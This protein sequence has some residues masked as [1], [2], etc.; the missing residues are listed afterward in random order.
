[1]KGCTFLIRVL[2]LALGAPGVSFA[3]DLTDDEA[4]AIL[5][6][7]SIAQEYSNSDRMDRPEFSEW[8]AQSFRKP[9]LAGDTALEK[10]ARTDW[11]A[12]QLPANFPRTGK[13][14]V[15]LLQKCY[16]NVWLADADDQADYERVESLADREWLRVA[17]QKA[18]VE[19]GPLTIVPTTVRRS[20]LEDPSPAPWIRSLNQHLQH[21]ASTTE[22]SLPLAVFEPYCGES[23]RQEPSPPPPPPPPPPRPAQ[24][25]F[26]APPNT[27]LTIISELKSDI[28]EIRTGSRYTASCRGWRTISQNPF[29]VTGT[30]Y[31]Y[32]AIRPGTSETH[33][34]FT[35]VWEN[36]DPN[37]PI[38]FLQ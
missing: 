18:G 10:K 17:F 20:S 2:A 9:F 7:K 37:N 5:I 12:A 31:R 27:T 22:K 14:R 35:V 29:P 25:Y 28:C 16:T 34:E 15:V 36:T 38:K 3:A 4:L 23:Q 1:M 21:R 6:R 26:S 19:Q 11:Y 32:T 33:G 30:R 13:V 8:A 24:F